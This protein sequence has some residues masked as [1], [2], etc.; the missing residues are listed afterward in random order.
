MDL[1]RI[2][3]WIAM[4]LFWVAFIFAVALALWSRPVPACEVCV[5][6]HVAATYDYGVVARAEA[7][8]RKVMFV[9][10]QGK[11]AAAPRSEAAIRK[12][13]AAVP[14]IDRASIRYSAFPTAV[15]FAWNPERYDSGEVLRTVN[16]GLG[17]SGLTLIA[18]KVIS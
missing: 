12:A 6:D 11:D 1:R 18:I 3:L 5:E 14:G 7:A 13:L 16:G 17:G 8:G 2:S 4:R 10:V 9:A 15:S